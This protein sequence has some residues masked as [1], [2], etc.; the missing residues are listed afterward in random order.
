[1][2]GCSDLNYDCLV[3][4]LGGMGSSVLY[5][6]ARR[7][8]NVCGL[9]QYEPV[10]CR[11]SSH[12]QFRV[13][14]KAYFEHPDYVPLLHAADSLWRELEA[15]SGKRLY[16]QIGVVLSGPPDGDAVR[17]TLI[18][19]DEHSLPVEKMTAADAR[20]RWP[21]LTFPDNHDV[22]LDADAGILA[23][24]ECV[25]QYIKL[26]KRHGADAKFNEQLVAW[27]S[28]QNSIRI[29]TQ[30]S[31][32]NADHVVFAGGAWSA[33]ILSGI[34]P[35]LNVLRKVQC[36][37]RVQSGFQQHPAEMPA[38]FF[39]T[40]TGAFYGMPSGSE[41]LKVARHSGGAHVLDPSNPNASAT[42]DERQSCTEFAMTHL[43]GIAGK[44][45]RTS[46]CLYTLTPDGH[47]LID[48]HPDNHR[49]LF[50]AGFSGHGFKFASVVGRILA[51]QV[52]GVDP[53]L[54]IRFL[55]A[56]RFQ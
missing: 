3:I 56:E 48:R 46:N 7:G 30:R 24:E 55:S 32:Y 41:Q 23:V 51:D 40:S 28:R 52:V 22:V 42:D 15:E 38:F 31:T 54:A 20:R 35:E 49:I 11:G 47:F 14:R 29:T 45:T 27:E 19:A 1:M 18:A 10:H 36:W 8:L 34:L 39:E 17:G 37:Y 2:K 44:P 4:G 5:H 9:E 12:G 50:A 25:S 26:A 33:G 6:L 21:M 43:R 53:G 16:R 13:F